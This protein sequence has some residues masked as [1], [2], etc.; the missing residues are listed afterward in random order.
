MAFIIDKD[1][2][3]NKV[4]P[5]DLK[6]I[7]VTYQR[8]STRPLKTRLIGTW[9]STLMICS[10]RALRKLTPSKPKGSFQCPSSTPNESESKYTFGIIAS[11]FFKFMINKQDI[12]ANPKKIL[13]IFDM[14]HP[15]SKKKVQQ[16][17]GWI[18]ALSQFISWSTEYCLF[19]FNVLH[20]MHNFIQIE[21]YR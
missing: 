12:N 17:I 18:I 2:Y 1:I 19:F 7:G 6:N 8:M 10:S 15:A 21:E 9:R 11:K 4:M 3:C 5:F 20:R 13:V 16:L 14:R